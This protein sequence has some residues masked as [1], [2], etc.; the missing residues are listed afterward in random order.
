MLIFKA[1]S[2]L[3]LEWC[4]I[5]QLLSWPCVIPS[6]TYQISKIKKITKLDRPKRRYGKGEEEEDGGRRKRWKN[7][8]RK[9]LRKRR[10]STFCSK[11]IFSL[12][13]TVSSVFSFLF[14]CPLSF[15][16][17]FL[18]FCP[19]SFHISFLF[20]CPLSFHISSG[21]DEQLKDRERIGE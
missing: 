8:E 9:I 16:I 4:S 10:N 14:F 19:L 2:H 7:E 13:I 18:F 11:F 5:I 12:H 15:H 1:W 17:S 6:K 3:L 20:F 21:K